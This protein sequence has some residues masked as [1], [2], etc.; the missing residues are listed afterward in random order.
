MDSHLLVENLLSLSW[1]ALV[2]LLAPI[3]ALLTRRTVPDVV[4]LV[5]ATLAVAAPMV[6]ASAKLADHKS[7]ST[8]EGEAPPGSDEVPEV[9][10]DETGEVPEAAQ[11]G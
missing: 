10:K 6:L 3:G 5:G 2:A 7:D 8:E 11:K 9:A 4:W 1:I